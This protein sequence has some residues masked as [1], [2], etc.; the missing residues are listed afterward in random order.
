MPN[1]LTFGIPAAKV[2]NIDK[3]T[4]T[5][6]VQHQQTL[7]TWVQHQALNKNQQR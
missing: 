5:T 1:H 6:W 7:T 3:Q 2:E 4:S